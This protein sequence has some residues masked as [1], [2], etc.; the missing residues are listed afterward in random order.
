MTFGRLILGILIGAVAGCFTGAAFAYPAAA[1]AL[2]GWQTTA[3]VVGWTGMA[4]AALVGFFV[5]LVACSALR[6]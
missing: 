5:S 4:V 6:R 2:A 1:L 3:D